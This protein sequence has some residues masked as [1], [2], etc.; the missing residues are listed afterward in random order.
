MQRDPSFEDRLSQAVAA[1]EAVADPQEAAAAADFA[2]VVQARLRASIWS[3]ALKFAFGFL[4]VWLVL[5]VL[6]VS[7]AM[8]G[9]S[10]RTIAA[11]GVALAWLV[12]VAT[13]LIGWRQLRL[14]RR[15]ERRNQELSRA[16]ER[17]DPPTGR[18]N[19]PGA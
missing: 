17:P 12:L 11:G 4:V 14:A 9:A 3:T 18:P 5:I 1:G 10:W 7:L 6:P 19:L 15:A 16:P 2:R 8:H 13:L